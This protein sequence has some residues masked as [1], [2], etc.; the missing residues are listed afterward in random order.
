VHIPAAYAE[1]LLAAGDGSA[2]RF[3]VTAEAL[4]AETIAA[5]ARVPGLAGV[6]VLA[7]GGEATIPAILAQAGLRPV[8]VQ[9]AD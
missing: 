3:R 9:H 5:L 2:D 4:C 7:P 1:R 8:K 6:H